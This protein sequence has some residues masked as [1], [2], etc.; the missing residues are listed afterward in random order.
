MDTETAEPADGSCSDLTL[1]EASQRY[2]V[3]ARTLAQHIRCGQLPAYKTHG[4]TG[5]HWLITAEALEAAGYRP[6]PTTADAADEDPRIVQLLGELASARRTAAA[7]RRRADDSDR[8]LGHA[9]LECGHLRA[10]LAATVGEAR[11]PAGVDLDATT[12]RWLLS[13]VRGGPD[14]T[15]QSQG[16][17]GS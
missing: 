14:I 15:P 10:A 6:R 11:P 7:E 17:R 9:Q 8:R 4:A 5:R 2:D 1:H 16:S 3:S 13:A 12:T